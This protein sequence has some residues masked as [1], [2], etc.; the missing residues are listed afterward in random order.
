MIVVTHEPLVSCINFENANDLS[1]DGMYVMNNGVHVVTNG[2][3]GIPANFCPEGSS[4]GYFNSS[5]LEIPFF[6]NN[7]YSL[8]NLKVTFDMFSTKALT[9]Y[10][11]NSQN[12]LI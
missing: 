8:P 6:A 11:V 3:D 5:Q 2:I 10:E 7:Y 9:Y 1:T 4:C 12:T